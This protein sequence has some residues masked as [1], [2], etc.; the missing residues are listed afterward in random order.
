[1]TATRLVNKIRGDCDPLRHF[2]LSGAP[3]EDFAAGMRVGFSGNYAI[4]YLHDEQELVIVRV[5][6]AARDAA[7]LA[8]RGGFHEE[9]WSVLPTPG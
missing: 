6:H 2:P 1:M 5:L 8:K 3:R 4:Y 9:P 7:A